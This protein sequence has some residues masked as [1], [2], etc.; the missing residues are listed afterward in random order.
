MVLSRK[1]VLQSAF[2]FGAVGAALPAKAQAPTRQSVSSWRVV[3]ERNGVHFGIPADTGQL[4]ISWLHDQSVTVLNLPRAD[5]NAL[6]WTQAVLPAQPYVTPELRFGDVFEPASPDQ[7]AAVG[8]DGL[9]FLIA[10]NTPNALPILRMPFFLIR[11]EPGSFAMQ[12]YAMPPSA[13]FEAAAIFVRGAS[14][15]IVSREGTEFTVPRS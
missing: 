11:V 14:I 15:V 9:R 1:S 3:V 8:W 12:T 5:P 2:A 6:G 13:R 7:V 4:V 10:V